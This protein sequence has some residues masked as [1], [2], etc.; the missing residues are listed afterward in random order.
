MLRY[1]VTLRALLQKAL[2]QLLGAVAAR[3]TYSFSSLLPFFILVYLNYT[4]IPRSFARH[5]VNS[6]P[7]YKCRLLL[8]PIFGTLDCNLYDL[9]SK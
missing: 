1:V 5:L 8:L 3:L 2:L 4:Y 6:S 9:D 7:A